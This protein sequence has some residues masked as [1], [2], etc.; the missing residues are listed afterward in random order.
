MGENSK[1]WTNMY[2]PLF[3]SGGEDD[4][5]YAYGIDGFHEV[6]ESFIAEDV[7]IYNMRMDVAPVTIR[8]I[9]QQVTSDVV[10]T[11]S[12]RQIIC[13]IGILKCG[14]Y[15]EAD[16]NIWIVC[17]LPDNNGIYEKAILWKCKNNIRFR[18]PIT[19]EI[20]EY[21]I[22][23]YNSTQYGTGEWQK[24]NINIGEAQ[25]LV[26][27]PYNE[28]TILLDDRF[29]F[30]MD[31][32][33]KH[34]TVFRITMVDSAAYAVGGELIHDDDGLL[35]WSVL[36]T[37]FNEK[38]DSR[39][40]MVADYYIDQAGSSTSHQI[41][42]YAMS[43]TDADGDYLL[44]IGETKQ[45]KVEFAPFGASFPFDVSIESGSECVALKRG[46]D[47]FSLSA[48][49]NRSNIG[50]RVVV[51]AHS[52]EAMCESRIELQISGF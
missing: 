25:Q 48:F 40:E 2:R 29:R 7:K 49:R 23:N 52:D 39:E 34:P 42:P 9:I 12:V 1:K 13:D 47:G 44:T 43:M 26:F 21:P 3:N 31:R 41:G 5:F 32:N 30:I 14:Q 51:V 50:K 10:S 28:E 46:T 18:S 36:E 4:E 15:I 24:T 6:L 17:S 45:I 37:Q 20:V 19:G 8:A 38:T 22:Y 16:G 33:K 27:I 11:S 35:M